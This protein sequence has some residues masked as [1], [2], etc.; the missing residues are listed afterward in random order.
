VLVDLPPEIE[1]HAQRN[2]HIT[3][4]TAPGIKPFY[5]N[6]LIAN[7]ANVKRVS[8]KTY[9][10]VLDGFPRN[11]RMAS[12]I[13]EKWLQ[14]KVADLSP[15]LGHPGGTCKVVERIV[16]EVSNQRLEDSL[17]DQVQNGK[18][19]SNPAAR[20]VYDPER[21]KG[22][23][24]YKL[25]LTPH[26]QYRMDLRGITVPE[27]RAALDNFFRTMNAERSRGD[28]DKWDK[29]NRGMKIEWHDKRT[30]TFFVF[31]G[32]RNE[33]TI[34]TTYRPGEP[35]PRPAAYCRVAMSPVSEIEKIMGDLFDQIA[36]RR[37]EATMR[38]AYANDTSDPFVKKMGPD[39]LGSL[40]TAL[41]QAT[42]D[43]VMD[44]QATLNGRP[45]KHF[46]K[47]WPKLKPPKISENAALYF[48]EESTPQLRRLAYK[49][50][51]DRARHYR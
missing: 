2:P 42:D 17:V 35:D 16:D 27:I 9:E 40:S 25:L 24:K 7:S 34:I 28:T 31:T 8:P 4:S 44:L 38:A 10:G 13:A 45:S 15:P 19:L 23:W 36:K 22:A 46:R 30:N 39:P 49:V 32:G 48:Y 5:S 20:Q 11:R 37:G 6:K 18:S 14:A 41:I 12:R 47:A 50:V 26:A 29:F 3:I 33:V 51:T 1:R 21:D 43:L